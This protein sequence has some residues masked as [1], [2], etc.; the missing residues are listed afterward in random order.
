VGVRNDVTAGR[1]DAGFARACDF[2]APTSFCG[3]VPS[4]GATS[5][6]AGTGDGAQPV[7]EPTRSGAS[8]IATIDLAPIAC[9]A[10]PL[11]AHVTMHGEH[12]GNDAQIIAGT[13]LVTK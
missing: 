10:I 4:T 2:F 7:L 13:Q 6:D 3:A 1:L 9:P 8:G 5:D 12:R 11:T